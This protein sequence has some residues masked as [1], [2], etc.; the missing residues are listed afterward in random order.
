MMCPSIALLAL[1]LSAASSASAEPARRNVVLMI[2]DDLGLDLGCYGNAVVRTPRIDG[3]AKNGVRFLHAYATTASCSASRAVIL[4]G[5]YT[6]SNGQYGHAHSPHNFHALPGVQGLPKIL[7]AA[8]YRTGIVGKLHVLPP[9]VFPFDAEITATKG[10]NRNGVQMGRLAAKFIQDGGSQPFF[11]VVGFADPHRSGKG[12]G[13]EQTYQDVP[14]VRYD[15]KEVRVPP[16]LPDTPEVREELAEYYQAVSRLDFNVGQILDALRQTNHLDDTLIIFLS[17]NGIPFPGAKT[18]QY[19]PGLHLPLLI[20]SPNQSRRGLSNEAMVSFVD[21]APTILDWA[22]VKPPY[23]LPGRS[24]LPI[25]EDE[26][27]KGWDTVFG[28]HVFHEITNYYPMRMVRTRQYKYILNLAHP[29]PFPFASDLYA[30]RTW[31]GIVQR[32]DKMLGRRPVQDYLQRPREELY[33]LTKDP[34]E[35][36][37]V[38]GD[39][40]YAKVL[41]EL[42]AQVKEWQERTKDPWLVKY[43]YE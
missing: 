5:L 15:P 28:S 16:F 18:T 13:N 14:E 42:R 11:L 10:G 40:Q 27:P 2:A 30:S 3:L 35:V 36:K 25:L 8:G 19:D 7:R 4:T 23:P 38:A 1:G 31:Q 22:G 43:R 20:L 33:D 37:N 32:G 21:I 24:I 26:H 29:L 9:E 41:A 34:L 12:F 6:H 39:P 17:D